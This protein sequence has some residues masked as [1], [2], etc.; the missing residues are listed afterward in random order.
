M[1]HKV[2]YTSKVSKSEYL[3]ARELATH[4]VALARAYGRIKFVIHRWGVGYLPEGFRGRVKYY[5][6]SKV[7]VGRYA[8]YR[9]LGGKTRKVAEGSA[10]R[11]ESVLTRL[12]A[13]IIRW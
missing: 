8:L 3:S 13:R 5:T 1:A 12:L 7:G 9:H 4:I 2:R 6:V 10:T 11:V